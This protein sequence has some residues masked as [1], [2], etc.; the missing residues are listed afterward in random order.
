[1]S[2][3]LLPILSYVFGWTYF[4]SW[5]L[6]FYPQ[7]LLNWHRRSTTGTTIDFPA[8]NILGFAAYFLSNTAFLYSSQIRQQY[9]A[10]NH[11]LSP[12]VKLNDV[13]FAAHA[14]ILSII[15]MSQ[16]FPWV[17]G[18]EDG[19]RRRERVSKTVM[20]IFIGS[21]MG[22]GGVAAMVL[23]CPGEVVSTG[24]AWI[25]VV[26]VTLLRAELILFIFGVNA[27][28]LAQ[29]Y[30]ISYVKLVVSL[31]KYMP[32]LLTNYRNKSTHGWSIEQILLDF[33]GGILSLSQLGIDSY[34][35]RDWS[36]VTG[37]PVKLALG[38]TS[39]LFDTAFLVQHYFLYPGAGK[40]EDDE[41]S[42]LLAS[43]RSGAV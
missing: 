9:A 21:I 22:V 40:N 20:G 33:I 10:R 30:A 12:T 3:S 4:A 28:Q 31:V 37:N 5:S 35:Q 7:P 2:A 8:I 24:W 15:S 42:P 13:V 43:E 16:Y 1:M 14:T 39:M 19:G 32:Q 38:Y 17:W 11:G 18:F 41:N 36:G 27:Y 29:I 26:S 6:S 23:S 25:D 34:I